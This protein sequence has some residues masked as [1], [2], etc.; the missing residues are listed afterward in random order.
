MQR[1][2]KISVTECLNAKYK[3]DRF[4]NA[5]KSHGS[6]RIITN[7]TIK[8]VPKVVEELIPIMRIVAQDGGDIQHTAAR[9]GVSIKRQG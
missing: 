5:V 9:L 4:V 6:N 2:E 1:T 8:I 7:T 3:E